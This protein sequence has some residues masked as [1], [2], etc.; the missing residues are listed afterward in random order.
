MI[1]NFLRDPASA[2]Q[3][4]LLILIS[5]IIVGPFILERFHLPG[6]LGLVLGGM[7]LGPYVL[8]WLPEGSLEGFGSIG[9]LYLMFM[10]GLELD[11]NLFQ[12]YRKV[13]ITFGLLTFTLPFLAGMGASFYVGLSLSA[14]ILM[15]SVWASHTLLAYTQVKQAGLS[16]N[17]SVATTVGATVITDTLALVV[18][19]MVTGITGSEG[20]PSNG[21]MVLSLLKIG[22]SLAVVVFYCIGILPRVGKWFFSRIGQSRASRF[23]FLLGGMLSA[24]LLAYSL[25]IEGIVGAFFAGIGLNRL[26]PNE[27][28]LMERVDFFG[29]T[30]FIPAFLVS[31]GMLIN[32]ALLF[33]INT[34]R[35]AII[36]ATALTLGKLLAAYIAG[37]INRFSKA[38]IGLMFSLTVAQAAATL[39][40]TMVGLKIGL[41][42]E[43][44]VNAV[45]LV[46]LVSIFASSVGVSVTSR[47]IQPEI[48]AIQPLGNNVLVVVRPSKMLH[49]LIRIASEIARPDA[50]VV[51][52]IVI[53]QEHDS[54][55]KRAEAE[56]LLKKAESFGSKEASDIEGVF[57]VDSSL[58]H[59]IASE[60]QERNGTLVLAEWQQ[61]RNIGQIIFGSDLDKLGAICSVPFVIG[62]FSET[63]PKRVVLTIGRFENSTGFLVDLQI[64]SEVAKRIS[65]TR[66]IPITIINFSANV[67]DGID[68]SFGYKLEL[69]EGGFESLKS[70]LIQGDLVVTPWESVRRLLNSRKNEIS[71]IADTVSVLIAA[72]PYRFNETGFQSRREI[73]SY[74]NSGR[75]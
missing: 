42:S 24:G 21:N 52:P 49:R 47:R 10:A 9:I 37:R 20:E 54:T 33:N 70:E 48:S 30:L 18:L 35:L 66:S 40:V 2:A 68:F 51:M 74:I 58:H 50:G 67:P 14:A 45:L 8:R 61:H 65:K 72:G 27:G 7:L 63:P 13:A 43:Q 25:G 69:I 32:P 31:V 36:F 19:A 29:T 23:V 16:N 15:G 62:R 71:Q 28:Q 3:W 73:K 75:D 39:A 55:G 5:I 41:F 4:V 22:G 17:K 59:G 1:L 34:I 57:R 6:L 60:I 38:E 44:I 46:V 64:A 12:Q 56:S 53:F 26:V 11:I